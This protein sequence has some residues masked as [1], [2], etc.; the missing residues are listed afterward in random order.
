MDC[1]FS[2]PALQS[3]HGSKDHILL[4]A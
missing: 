3:W 4:M 1:G 2:T